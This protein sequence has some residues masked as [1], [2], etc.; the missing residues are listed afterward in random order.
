ME[1]SPPVLAT[2]R[3]LLRPFTLADAPEVMRMAGSPEVAR[4]TL[5]IPHPYKTGAAESWIGAQQPAFEEGQFITFAI[6]LTATG[7][8]CGAIGL[9]LNPRDQNAEI[10]YW[11]GAEYWGLGYCT[12]AGRAVLALGFE[13]FKLHRICSS[14]FASNPAS[15]RVMEKLG[16]TREGCRREHV[17]KWGR[18]EDRVDYGILAG[19]WRKIS[20]A[21]QTE[22]LV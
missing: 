13:K 21:K 1:K 6:V 7:R 16:M 4:S 11:L 12:E 22:P 20:L 8:L 17:Q 19:E 2:K 5:N 9:Q 18:F 14:H 10:G 15:G 3:L